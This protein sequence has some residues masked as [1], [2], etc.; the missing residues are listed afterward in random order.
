M[1]LSSGSYYN[2]KAIA[3][4]LGTV[5][6]LLVVEYLFWDSGSITSVS[7]LFYVNFT[8]CMIVMLSERSETNFISSSESTNYE[9]VFDLLLLKCSLFI[10][11]AD[12]FYMPDNFHYFTGVALLIGI[13]PIV[14]LTLKTSEF[15]YS[16]SATKITMYLSGAVIIAFFSYALV[17]FSLS[18]SFWMYIA[19]NELFH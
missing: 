2:S 5:L 3:T 6:L 14:T 1:T 18:E 10:V 12:Y 4:A 11:M 17:I 8:A 13:L 19:P 9:I 15:I 7:A 16:N